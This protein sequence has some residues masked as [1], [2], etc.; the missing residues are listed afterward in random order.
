MTTDVCAGI[1]RVYVDKQASAFSQ[2]NT[3]SCEGVVVDGVVST[4]CSYSA[5]RAKLHAC[6]QFARLQRAAAMTDFSYLFMRYILLA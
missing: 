6:H 1:C 2:E 4:V 5:K 3:Y